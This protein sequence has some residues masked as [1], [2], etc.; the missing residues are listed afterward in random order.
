MTT[1]AGRKLTKAQLQDLQ[2][3]YRALARTYGSAISASQAKTLAKQDV[4]PQEWQTRL[5][6][7]ERVREY[8]PAFDQFEA[9]AKAQG[10]L[11]ANAPFGVKER[12]AFVLK[13]SPK[14]FYDLWEAASVRTAAVTAGFQIGGE[15]DMGVTRDDLLGIAKQIPGRQSEED[16]R[17][18]FSELAQAV[19]EVIPKDKLLGF[20]INQRDLFQLQFGGPRQAE[21]ADRVDRALKTYEGLFEDRAQPQLVPTAKGAELV[22]MK[23]SG[24]PQTQ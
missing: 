6:A 20:G 1:I 3:D 5:E 15:G 9:E 8:Q 10:L 17:E 11:S 2:A 7:L 16:F 13:R 12:L 21:I 4:S 14:Q 24:K 18:D 19:K 23:L 22:G